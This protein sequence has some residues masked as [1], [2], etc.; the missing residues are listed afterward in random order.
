MLSFGQRTLTFQ[1]KLPSCVEWIQRFWKTPKSPRIR[2]TPYVD[3]VSSCAISFHW[4]IGTEG[5]VRQGT[6]TT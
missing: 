2:F 6:G 1:R 5:E 3:V 4:E